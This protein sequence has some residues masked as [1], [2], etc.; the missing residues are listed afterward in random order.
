MGVPI[1]AIGSTA[2]VP[3][4]SRIPWGNGLHTS[5]RQTRRAETQP[6]CTSFSSKIK[7]IWIRLSGKLGRCPVFTASNRLDGFIVAIMEPLENVYVVLTNLAR[8]RMGFG[9]QP[10]HSELQG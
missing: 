5:N 10:F 4:S 1:D 7:K 9:T 2:D 6:C 3:S 8:C